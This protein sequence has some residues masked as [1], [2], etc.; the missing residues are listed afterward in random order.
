MRGIPQNLDIN[1]KWVDEIL[2][3]TA[4]IGNIHFAGGEPSLN[5]KAIFGILNIVKKYKIPVISYNVITN[6]KFVNNE[7]IQAIIE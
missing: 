3:N 6:G 4:F 5:P 7:F 2:K 1:M